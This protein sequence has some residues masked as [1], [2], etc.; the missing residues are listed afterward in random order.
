MRLPTV[1]P[2]NGPRFLQLTGIAAPLLLPDVGCEVIAPLGAGAI[3]GMS[4]G[5]RAFEGLRY[6]PGGV[7][8]PDFVLN[9]EA[10]RQAS[11]LLAGENFGI[12]DDPSSAVTRLMA[13]GIRVV[14]APRFGAKFHK[15]CVSRGLLPVTLDEAAIAEVADWVVSNPGIEMKV[16]LDGQLIERP[17]RT[18]VTFDVDPRTRN[19]LLMGLD[20]LDESRQ[21]TEM[22]AALREED[23]MKRPWLYHERE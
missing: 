19:K 5:E 1:D 18:P 23:R 10:Y 8:N 11:I 22:T 17:G 21:Y 13:F 9:Q 12:G 15:S 6:L 20:D 4:A 16:D 2:G 14:A 7:E 3:S